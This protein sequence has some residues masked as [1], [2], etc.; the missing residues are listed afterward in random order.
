MTTPQSPHS[1]V[2][3]VDREG[4]IATLW[5]DRPEKLNAFAPDFWTDL[6]AIIEH[7][8]DDPEVRVIVIQGRGKAFTAGI[9]LV[10]FGPAMMGG[11]GLESDGSPSTSP[12]AMRKD[13]YRSV[14]RMQHTFTSIADCPKP[15][16]AAVH[17]YCLGAG[18]DL[19]TA[20]DIRF[21][22]ADA[23]FSVKET[24]IAMV[25]D[26]GT[27]QRLP[28]IVDPGRVAELVYT[29][30]EFDAA[31]AY[32]MGLI[33]RVCADAED[34]Q[35]QAHAL[36]EE[37]ATNSPLVVQGAKSVLKAGENRTV[38]EALDYV[39]LWNASFITSNDFTE[40]IQ[41]FIEKRPPR[42]TGT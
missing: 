30:K 25:A 36:A 13:L 6:P 31:E 19:I 15:V 9:D 28:K 35:K 12:V 38:E 21:G 29:G 42:F 16:I 39:A 41:A 1:D 40:A 23:V 4:H 20:C 37:I 34:V 17:G 32:D 5:L 7:L 2:I 3:S 8:G 14:K 24:K 26:V 10:A 11:G 33:T 27:M 18:L 22:S